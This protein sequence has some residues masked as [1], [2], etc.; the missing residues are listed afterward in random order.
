[1]IVEGVDTESVRGV[2]LKTDNPPATLPALLAQRAQLTPDAE[3]VRFEK[4]AGVTAAD[5][6]TGA[7]YVA[8]R[9]ASLVPRGATVITCLRPGRAAL[10]VLFALSALG[11]VEV[12]VALDV[13]ESAA[14]SVVRA[15]EPRL[16]LTEAAVLEA[17]PGLAMATTNLSIV[18]LDGSRNDLPLLGE[19]PAHPWHRPAPE[20]GDPLVMLS[21]SGTTGRAKTAVLPHFAA[22]RHARRVRETMG[23]GPEDVLLNVFPWN[24]INVRHA[25][26]LPALLAGARLVAHA[27]FSASRFWEICRTERVTAFNFMGAMLAMLE[28]H[29]PSAA[30]TRHEVRLAYG[31]PAPRELALRFRDRFG[32]IPLEAYACT[33][34]GDVATNTPEDWRP[35]T[36]GRVVAEYDVAILDEGGRSSPRGENG[37][38]AVR[39]LVP[40]LSFTGYAGDPATTSE[41]WDGEWFRTGDRGRLDE[42]GYLIFSGR[43]ADVVRR[44]GENIATWDVEEVVRAMPGVLDVAAFGVDSELTE[45]ELAVALVPQEG[46]ELNTR[47]VHEWCRAHLP[48][49]AVPRYV[50]VVADLPRTASGKVRKTVLSEQGLAESTWDAEGTRAAEEQS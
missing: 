27:R 49:H 34:L 38:I 20:P 18:L 21:T 24:H 3:V 42:D 41:V 7:D 19:L 36:A 23:Y 8:A 43:R 1:M 50:R 28:R 17:N 5:L 13:T 33:E 37:L 44:R 14:C 16:I 30:D 48:R 26:L 11:A 25:A 6:A 15:T 29:P 46:I 35:G 9:L 22:I 40:H 4:G 10:E 45:Q 2:A 39:P 12:P 31:G 47:A 32:V